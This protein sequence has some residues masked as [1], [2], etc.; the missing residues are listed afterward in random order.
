[1]SREFILNEKLYA[2]DVI[3]KRTL[4]ENTYV[5]IKILAK[6]YYSM[7]YKHKEIVRLIE[8]FMIKCD[9]V[10]N[11]VYWRDEIEKQVK[12]SKNKRLIML[13]GIHITESEMN[14][15]KNLDGVL[16]QRLMFTM[17]CVAKYF[18]AVRDANNNWLNIT[19]RDLFALANIMVTNKRKALMVNDLWQKEYVGYSRV[20]DNTNLNIKIVDDDS[21]DEIVIT[22]FRNIGNQ[23]R[24]YCGEKYIA[25]Q[26]CGIVIKS[27]AAAH[28][29]CDSCAVDV[30]TKQKKESRENSAA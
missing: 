17:L 25:C 21:P 29:Y 15:V 13:D 16:S 23:Y 9:P 28:K 26:E 1:M 24:R 4:G 11:M 5:T 27:N 7:G 12:A 19:D 8:D 30:H 6:Y 22:D 10:A 18:N 2:E 20:I 3:K 14:K